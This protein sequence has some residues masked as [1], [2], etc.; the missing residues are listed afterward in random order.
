MTGTI[1]RW[2]L[3]V[4]AIAA[5]SL[6]VSCRSDPSMVKH[7]GKSRHK[8]EQ[9]VAERNVTVH[10]RTPAGSVV[11]R[12][13][14]QARLPMPTVTASN[15]GVITG[16]ANHVET[17]QGRSAPQN[18][19]I[20]QAGVF[21]V[22]SLPMSQAK[23]TL[24]AFDS[25]AFP[26]RGNVPTT[27]RPFLD[28]AN[29]E[30]KAHRTFGNRVYW[31]DEAYSDP[32][33]LIH[34][35]RGFDI[36]RPG[37]MVVYFHGHGATLERDVQIRQQV[38]AQISESGMNAVLVAPQLAVDARDFSPGKFWEP[39]GLKRFVDEAAD[40]M[41]KMQGD[42][43]SRDKFAKMPI[44]IVAYSGGYLAT[45]WGLERGGL[46]K[47]VRGVVLLDALYGDIDKFANWIARQRGNSFFVSSFANSTR[48]QNAH[49]ERILTERDI[50]VRSNLDRRLDQ[51]S[52]VFLPTAP[53]TR[54]RDFVTHAWVDHPIR[55]VLQK[56]S[57]VT[58]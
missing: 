39:G 5:L 14:K 57:M 22:P 49:L 24:V 54:H 8:N 55:D 26:Y 35:P 28:I 41:A 44:V 4:L 58:R 19:P 18:R 20:V 29:G 53:D 21:S 27:H 56:M 36:N 45:A 2:L 33:V 51:G 11:Q 32:R 10:V 17:Q 37:V 50:A 1:A 15:P 16:G 43:R 7:G 34:I 23:T 30:R 42:P 38:P 52:V 40:K 31:E 3:R 48:N 13:T 25:S 12:E 46:G 47:R 9:N 6:C